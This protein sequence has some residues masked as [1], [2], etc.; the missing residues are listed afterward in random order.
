MNFSLKDCNRFLSQEMFGILV[1][2]LMSAQFIYIRQRSVQLSLIKMNERLAHL[3]RRM[4]ASN[5]QQYQL[6]WSRYL[7]VNNQLTAISRYL[8]ASQ[9]FWLSYLTLA[10]VNYTTYQGIVTYSVLFMNISVMFKIFLANFVLNVAMMHYGLIR[11]CA[12]VVKGN[13]AIH[14]ELHRFCLQLQ[15]CSIKRYVPKIDARHLLMVTHMITCNQK[16]NV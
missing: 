1:F 14:S 9:K 7:S 5:E 13:K 12:K 11:Q 10:F 4:H 6:V 2:V 8:H 16:L 15:F 3:S